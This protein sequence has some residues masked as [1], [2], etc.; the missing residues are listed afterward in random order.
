V[1]RIVDRLR[2]VSAEHALECALRLY[3]AL[4]KSL[5]S[6]PSSVTAADLAEH[7]RALLPE[8]AE[9]R[10]SLASQVES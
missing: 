1:T 4:A 3:D 10:D 8:A 9:L 5:E 6:V 7:I 2:A